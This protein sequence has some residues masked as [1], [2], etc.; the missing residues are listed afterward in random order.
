MHCSELATIAHREASRNHPLRAVKIEGR[1]ARSCDFARRAAGLQTAV[2]HL[3]YLFRSAEEYCGPMYTSSSSLGRC[4][5]TEGKVEAEPGACL[6]REC[7][8]QAAATQGEAAAR[9]AGWQGRR[10]VGRTILPHV[11]KLA[12]SGWLNVERAAKHPTRPPTGSKTH[13]SL[14]P[15]PLH[16]PCRTFPTC[17]TSSRTRRPQPSAVAP[18]TRLQD[19]MELPPPLLCWTSTSAPRTRTLRTVCTGQILVL[20]TVVAG[21]TRRVTLRRRGSSRCVSCVRPVFFGGG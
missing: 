20:V 2:V 8:G 9:W 21:S 13:A 11:P 7:A 17:R 4:S 1:A 3:G 6:F 10:A 14:S 19:T 18:R 15:S 5:P 16:L 12:A